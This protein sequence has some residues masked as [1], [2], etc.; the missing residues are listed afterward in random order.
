MHIGRYVALWLSFM[1]FLISAG[2]FGRALFYKV[3]KLFDTE[4]ELYSSPRFASQTR[5]YASLNLF[6]PV[7]FSPEQRKRWEASWWKYLVAA[8]AAFGLASLLLT[9]FG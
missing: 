4:D 9:L 3:C 7:D 1:L 8:C 6:P 5:Q 2:L